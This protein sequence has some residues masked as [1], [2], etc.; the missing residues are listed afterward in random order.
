MR[1]YIFFSLILL[2]ALLCSPDILA[3]VPRTISVQGVLVDASNSPLPD[4]QHQ[5][6]ISL[7]SSA[8]GGSPVYTDMQSTTLKDGLFNL[9]IGNTT[10][11]PQNLNFD[12][13]Y[14]LG[15]SVDGGPEM[16]PRTPFTSVPYA[17]HSA[18]ATNADVADALA[19]GAD[20]VVGSING[21]DGDIVIQGDGG[22]TVTKN[23]NTIVITS[24]GGSANGIAGVQ[25]NDGTLDIANPTGPVATLGIADQSIGSTKLKTDAV[26]SEKI[27]AEAVT[28]PKLADAAVRTEKVMDGAITTA[29]LNDEAVTHAKLADDAVGTSKLHDNAVTSM[30]LAE[31]SVTTAK[32]ADNAVTAAKIA[33]DA[34]TT[35]KLADES[36]SN[37]K[38][39]PGA[40]SLDKLATSGA[41]DGQV[42][43]FNAGSIN[44][45]DLPAG[46]GNGSGFSIPYADTMNHWKP[47]IFVDNLGGDG[48]TARAIPGR[49]AI[50]GIV[51]N[52]GASFYLDAGVAGYA[53]DG[54]GVGGTSKNGAGVEGSSDFGNGGKFT[55]GFANNSAAAVYATTSGSGNAVYAR[56]NSS[57]GTAAAIEGVT[58]SADALAAGVLGRAAATQSAATYGVR[59]INS[60]VSE[61]GAGVYGT[62]A[63]SGIGVEGK[64]SGGIGVYGESKGYPGVKGFSETG[65][66]AEGYSKGNAGVLGSSESNAGV[67]G[68]SIT[69]AGVEGSST[70]G[71]GVRAYANANSPAVLS[72]SASAQPALRADNTNVGTGV[73]A[74]TTTGVAVWGY[75]TSGVGVRAYSGTE[76]IIEAHGAGGMFG[77]L[78]FRVLQD[79]N[80]RCDG[81]FTGGGADV[82]EAFDFEGKRDQ[83]EAGDVLI[84]STHSDRKVMKSTTAYSTAVA[85]VYA[86]KPGVLLAPYDAEEDL[87]QYIPM[88]MMGVIPTKVTTE[89]GP[90]RRGDLLVTASTPGHAMKAS[91]VVVGGIGVYPTG[92]IIGKALQNFDGS[93]SGLIEVLVNVK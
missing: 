46:N 80:V 84:V 17:L 33:N 54:R 87:G 62:H 85:G 78:R 55:I 58:Q 22:T 41:Q 90:I 18:R 60:S 38:I 89:N 91:P 4:G 14:F 74:N 28:T 71:P 9:V 30:K 52:A 20:G 34:V 44:W 70:Q 7:Y 76:N 1:Q 92:A 57:S 45:A 26:T 35:N 3:Q 16:T 65:Y 53:I 51:S 25:N 23:G 48:L 36:V 27:F 21:L 19:P 77:N 72:L 66:G 5:I 67:K 37:A 82:A 49:N 79:G 2:S 68:F 61:Y 40:V 47:A 83:Y 73:M 88:G 13:Q 86:T 6:R 42:P 69:A 29:K 39:A 43:M 56:T 15:I 31:A 75:A 10:P 50:R 11:I 63:G 93:G 24:T 32:I 8:N 64:S 12:T 59:G 81:A